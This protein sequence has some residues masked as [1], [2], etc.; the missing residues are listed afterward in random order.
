MIIVS[1][2]KVWY[3]YARAGIEQHITIMH[4]VPEVASSAFVIIGCN[5][6]L[7]CDVSV[8]MSHAFPSKTRLLKMAKGK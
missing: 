3:I 6:D 2:V 5:I 8:L 7:M 4:V 1:Y